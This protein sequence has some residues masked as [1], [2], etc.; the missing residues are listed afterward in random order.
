M[1]AAAIKDTRAKFGG[2]R[3]TSY[4]SWALRQLGWEFEHRLPA[5]TLR[6][7]NATT[8]SVGAFAARWA[9]WLALAGFV[10]EGARLEACMLGCE[11]EYTKGCWGVQ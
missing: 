7:P 9:G 4:L 5:P 8:K 3:G 2:A 11:W 10:V 6:Y 1:R